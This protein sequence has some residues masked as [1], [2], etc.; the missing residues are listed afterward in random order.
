MG[1]KQD[2]RENA[3]VIKS[4]CLDNQEIK[5]KPCANKPE[6]L[7]NA[8]D[9]CELGPLTASQRREEA[10]EKRKESALFQRNVVLEDH[11]CNNDENL[12]A[13]KIGNYSKAL[14]H[15]LLGEVDLNAYR[16]WIK[17]LTN[18][19]PEEF[20]SL[21]MGGSVKFTDPQA[22]Y[23]YEM[24][25]PDSHHLTIEPPP[26]FCSER[27]AG[28]I[29]E[30]YWMALTRDVAFI[31]YDNNSE[32]KAAAEDLSTFSD[33]D[34]PKYNGKVT[35]GTLFRGNVSGALKGPFISQFLLKDIP[36]GAKVIDQRYNVPMENIDYMTSFGEW[37]NIQNGK[38][39]S[40]AIKL[41]PI[42]RYI[43]D[44]RALGGYVHQDTSIQAILTACLILLGFGEE[45][46]SLDNPYLFSKTQVGFSTFGAPH[47]L[48]FVTRVARMAL[49]A[50][51]YQKF[52]VHR[53]LR[54]EEFGGRVYNHMIN[55]L[56]YPINSELFDSKVLEH[57]YRKFHTYLLP[58]A[59]PEG[60]PTHA[61]YPAGHATFVGAGVTILKAFFNED[62]II[63][64]PVIASRD[65]LLLLPYLTNGLT[66]GGE[67][68]KLAANIALGRDFAGVH[69]RSD[70]SEGM[71]LGE[72]VAIGLLQDYR[73]TY[74]ES[75]KGFS[76][77]K[78][79]GT[80]VI[81]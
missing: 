57:V 41:D 48:D 40:S 31:D 63:P 47:V 62:Y 81:I 26:A 29:A 72:A 10:Y 74:N 67:L 1:E 35:T 46:Q 16:I 38:P 19:N 70:G 37:L 78:F 12:Y 14:P 53:R 7:D 30:D 55:A 59:F 52:L 68:N 51:W 54:P 76:F 25:G 75:F 58:I 21:P 61:A 33:F 28:E 23:A 45:A 49:E 24:I 3:S 27:E 71:K 43:R 32:T 9:L 5:E 42:L 20:E 8:V 39:P 50:A 60:C 17:T 80:R 44:G 36:F 66:V 65:G 79:D 6:C 73:E 4:E 13:N 56:R 2:K 15:N 18:G 34:G 22:A 64:N 11:K 77:T 69:W